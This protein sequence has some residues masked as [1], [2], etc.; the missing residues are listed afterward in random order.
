[1]GREGEVGEGWEVEEMKEGRWKKKCEVRM[2]RREKSRRQS[3][4]EFKEHQKKGTL[5]VS[6]FFV[7][8]NLT[9]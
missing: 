5:D 2:R 3:S 8:A 6:G 9:L 7:W 1:M 4:R